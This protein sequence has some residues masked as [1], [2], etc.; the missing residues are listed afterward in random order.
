MYAD[1]VEARQVDSYAF[2]SCFLPMMIYYDLV[3]EAGRVMC[4]VSL[5][6]R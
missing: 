2:S 4:G 6:V 5:A 1:I 3:L